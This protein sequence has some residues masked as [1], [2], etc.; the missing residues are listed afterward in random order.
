MYSTVY[1]N[2]SYYGVDLKVEP[3]AY[4]TYAGG[5]SIVEPDIGVDYMSVIIEGI[6]YYAEEDPDPDDE[7][8]TYEA[9]KEEVMNLVEQLGISRTR[10]KFHF[11]E[12]GDVK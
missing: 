5:P 2:P 7:T 1:E 11:D 9:L 3:Y 12:E 6:E 4:V 10:L 8:G